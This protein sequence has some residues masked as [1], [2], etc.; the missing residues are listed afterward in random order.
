MACILSCKAQATR[1]GNRQAPKPKTNVSCC[2]SSISEH[3]CG[4]RICD[5]R[6]SV[7]HS[8]VKMPVVTDLILSVSQ[9]TCYFA[10]LLASLR[11]A[12]ATGKIY[13]LRASAK[14]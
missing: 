11:K 1:R 4:L 8:F 5:W 12:L 7:V 13:F 2:G 14:I 3:C 10:G 9:T 6:L